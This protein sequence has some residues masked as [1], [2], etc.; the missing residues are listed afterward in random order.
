M[1]VRFNQRWRPPVNPLWLRPAHGAE[2]S[3][4]S[5]SFVNNSGSPATVTTARYTSN[6]VAGTRIDVGGGILDL[7][8]SGAD[9]T[10]KA[11]VQFYYS[12]AITGTQEAALVLRYWNGAKWPT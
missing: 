10:D 5:A 2:P 9:S 3:G 8:I 6:P 7:Q 4:L 12:S 11:T 1:W